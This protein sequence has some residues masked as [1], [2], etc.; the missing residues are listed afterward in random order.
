MSNLNGVPN[1]TMFDTSHHVQ[2]KLPK[3]QMPEFNGDPLKWPGFWDRYEIYIGL[4]LSM[5]N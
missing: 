2:C 3:M 1:R 5:E 4:T